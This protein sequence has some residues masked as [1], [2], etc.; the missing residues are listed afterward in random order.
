MT[1][2]ESEQEKNATAQSTAQQARANTTQDTVLNNNKSLNGA[3]QDTGYYKNETKAG[4]AATTAGYDAS[5]AN[6]KASMEAAGVSGR[7]GVVQGNETA[8]GAKEASD[9]AQ[10][11]TNAFADTEKQQL[12]ANAEDVAISGQGTGAG[13]TYSGQ[14]TTA[15]TARQQ[16]GAE[17]WASLGKAVTG[18]ATTALAPGVS[19]LWG[20][21]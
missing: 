1:P 20:T 3:V 6:L 21:A 9:L 14:A 12:A 10:V 5:R 15:E 7:S 17:N 4:T 18:A 13:T 2:S 16:Q 19:K 8:L 11:Q